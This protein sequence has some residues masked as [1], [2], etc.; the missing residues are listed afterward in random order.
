MGTGRFDVIVIG[1]GVAGQTV[2]EALATAGRTVAIVDRREYGGTCALR[3]CEPKKVLYSAAETVERV[4]DASGLTI[5]STASLDWRELVTFKR[6]FTDGRTESITGWL[7]A[8]GVT[9][10]H[11]AVRFTSHG[12]IDLD[13]TPYE[14]DTFVVATG[15]LP[16]PLGIP[17]EDLVIDSEAFMEAT[18]LGRRVVFIGGG[19]VSFEFA[20][21]AAAAG[22]SVTILHRGARVLQEFDPDLADLLV[23][24][25][26]ELGIDVV[27][28]APVAAIRRAS[29][30]L[31]VVLA[32]GTSRPC[33]TAVHGA[34]R[35][36]DLGALDLERAGIATGPRGVE[37]D[38]SMRSTTNPRVFAVGDA[39]ALGAPLTP[40]GVAQARIA[41][42]AIQGKAA[43]VFDGTVTPS[44]AFTDPVLAGVGL[45]EREASERGLDFD[46]RFHDTS[47][48]ASSHRVGVTASGAKVLVERNTGQILGAHLL[49]PH[50]EDVIN[51]FALAMRC[52]AT[53][54]DLRSA[55]WA[56][57][58]ASYEIVNLV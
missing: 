23:R 12:T 1:T 38:A 8:A 32:D 16:R 10:L 36:P 56:Y 54:D 42:R 49:G 9:P 48:W 41:S 6:S 33:D 50:A 31:E 27:T 19:Y 22:V 3:G 37:V 25:Y 18:D 39:A 46:V 24:R 11:G 53:A 45:S 21:V 57:P 7:V 55:V 40:V 4:R 47:A 13:G 26:R 51:V 17:G 43:P 29:D 28:D 52:G 30:G 14:A 44:A 35:V 34:G 2:A 58:S 20:H 15:A 5:A